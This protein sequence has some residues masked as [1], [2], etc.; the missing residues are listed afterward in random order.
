MSPVAMRIVLAFLGLACMTSA[1]ASTKEQQAEPVNSSLA[2]GVG[3]PSDS[4]L[5]EALDSVAGVDG[6]GF[7]SWSTEG[8]RAVDHGSEPVNEHGTDHRMPFADAQA[9]L[10]SAVEKQHDGHTPSDDDI[11]EFAW[12]LVREHR[13]ARRSLTAV[14]EAAFAYLNEPLPSSTEENGPLPASTEEASTRKTSSSSRGPSAPEG[15]RKPAAAARSAQATVGWKHTSV[16]N[17]A[18]VRKL[19]ESFV[20][21]GH[22]APGFRGS[23]WIWFPWEPALRTR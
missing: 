7:A 14:V 10:S 8:A 21:L 9:L 12:S 11:S 19:R 22:A 3:V 18:N 5:L 20:S 17:E 15:S 6:G 1:V 23:S 2:L 16:V 13:A 4:T